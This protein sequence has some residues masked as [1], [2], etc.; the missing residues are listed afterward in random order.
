ME[1]NL[2]GKKRKVNVPVIVGVVVVVLAAAA[3]GLYIHAQHT[4]PDRNGM[5]YTPPDPADT[6]LPAVSSFESRSAGGELGGHEYWEVFLTAGGQA[7]ARVTSQATHSDRE[8]VTARLMQSA[9]ASGRPLDRPLR[10]RIHARL[11]FSFAR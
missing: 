11:Y 7:Y 3:V 5:V 8:K 2:S 10:M 6:S 4:V 9:T 1:Q